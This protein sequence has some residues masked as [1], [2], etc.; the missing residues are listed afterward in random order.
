[1]GPASGE[2][3]L[4][5]VAAVAVATAQPGGVVGGVE[6]IDAQGAVAELEHEEDAC[7]HSRTARYS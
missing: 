3:N 4:P 1:M 7:E 6:H 2:T 5:D